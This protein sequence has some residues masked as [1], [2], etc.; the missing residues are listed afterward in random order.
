MNKLR[1]ILLPAFWTVSFVI[2]LAVA[3]PNSQEISPAHRLFS[4]AYLSP[5]DALQMKQAQER[6]DPT[7]VRSRYVH[8]DFDYLK[9]V[10]SIVLNLLSDVSETA[11]RE[12]VEKRSESRYSWFGRIDGMEHSSVVLTVEDGNMAGNITINGK[13]YQVRPAGSGIY[14]IRE[15]DQSAFPSEA[16]P[17]LVEAPEDDQGPQSSSSPEPQLDDGS[18]ID[19][20][21][22][23][24]DDAA[25][26]SPNIVSE[27]QLAID[28]TN[29]SYAKSGITQR[30]R[31]VRTE[32]VN[33]VETGNLSADLHCITDQGDGCLDGV[34]AWRDTYGA[35]MVSFWVENGG[36]YCGI[37]YLMT[38]VSG[39]FESNAFS[40]VDRECAT[41]YYTFGHELGHNMGAHHDRYV[42]SGQGA[43]PYSYGYVYLPQQ[44]RT[45]M[46]YNTQC[47]DSGLSCT[48]VQYWSNPD[49]DYN[50][51]PVGVPEGAPDSA[52]NRKT[53]NN[54]AYTV[55]NFRLSGQ[56]SFV[57]V[58]PG[59]WA[60][61]YIYAIYNAGITTGCSQNPLKYCPQDPVTRAQMAAFIVRAVEGEPDVGY[62]GTGSPFS[63]VSPTSVFCKYIKRLSE[64]GITLGCG[65]GNFCPDDTV[66]RNQMAAFLVRAVEGEP[67]ADY[68]D[69]GSPFSDVSPSSF[70]CKYIKRLSE[71]GITNG[72]G[73]GNY[74]PNGT[75]SRTQMAAFLAR[76]FLGME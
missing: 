32:E 27:I 5:T 49:V 76:A 17:I 7:I 58:P 4:D 74:C 53:L 33:Y 15:I 37:A 55:A 14:S 70:F 47:T 21:V 60:E 46:A 44:W 16:A 48:R 11:V 38:S 67:D 65:E 34:H 6:Q 41:G 62:C 72:C 73:D 1:K 13:I 71:L 56:E 36:A 66:T 39:S 10:E 30:L 59:Y 42:T 75:V 61:D 69:T 35:D 68:C 63:D 3:T 23:Y 19:V 40:V 9:E 31:L 12:R 22:V 57:D 51:I 8:V 50:G 29:T 54:T 26:A 20:M 28:E 2:G 43:Y 18:I 24:T 52:D 64:L 45:I 25:A